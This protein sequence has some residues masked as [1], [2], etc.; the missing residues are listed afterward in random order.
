MS[1]INMSRGTVSGGETVRSR[2]YLRVGLAGVLAGLVFFA[3]SVLTFYVLGVLPGLLFNPA[4]QGTKVIAVVQ[5]IEPAPLL[6]R[7]PHLVLAGW[8]VILIGYAF[9]FNHIK[10]LWPQRYGSCVWRLALMIWLFS[11]LFFQFQGPLK[12]LA[13]PLAPFALEL[14]FWGICALGASAVIVGIIG[15][16]GSR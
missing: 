15:R 16:P 4:F 12:L 14:G 5:E 13:E 9:L 7:A 3:L 11:L 1:A 8:A 10:P 6:Q 2:I